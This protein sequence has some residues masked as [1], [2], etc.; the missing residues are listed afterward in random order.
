MKNQYAMTDAQ[1]ES[2]A[3][4]IASAQEVTS[5]GRTTYLRV[6]VTGVQ[7][8][9]GKVKR[10]RVLVAETQLS[11]LEDV[12]SRYYAAVLRGVTSADVEALTGLE[13]AELT[14]RSIERNRRSTFARTA[15]SV[16]AGWIKAGG[17]MR[18]LDANE[19]T[20]DPLAAEVRKAR[21][22]SSVAY[23]LERHTKAIARL[24]TAEAAE[25]PGKARA[26]IEAAIEALQN[27]LDDLSPSGNVPSHTITQVLKGR[28]AHTRQPAASGRV[29]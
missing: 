22:V 23:S 26:D 11:V 14:R 27:V 4:D 20:R 7:A 1:V 16:L 13:Q 12:A 28:P 8:T 25:D 15:K 18:S 3:R 24:V 19:V 9:L 21:G 5:G 17:D 10:G 29:Q 6:L 2:L